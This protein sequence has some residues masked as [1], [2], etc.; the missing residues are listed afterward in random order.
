M[1]A[2]IVISFFASA[3]AV[4]LFMRRA[5]RHA[6]LYGTDMPQR[7]H[8]G[9]VPRLGGAGIM[10]GMGV[11]WLAA[12]ITGTDPFNV[13]WPVKTSMLTLLCIAPASSKT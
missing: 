3:F 7:F 4:Q 1:I 5:R 11:A 13:S 10:F 6:R 9:H 12:G 8:K 2:L